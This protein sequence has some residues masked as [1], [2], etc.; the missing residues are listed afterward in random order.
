M[1]VPCERFSSVGAGDTPLLFPSITIDESPHW[2]IGLAISAFAALVLLLPVANA[3]YLPPAVTAALD[4]AGVSP[5]ALALTVLPVMAGPALLERN[6]A[7]PFQPASTMKLVTTVAA[8]DLLGANYRG[9]TELLASGRISNA[10]LHGN[11]YLRGLADADLDMP[12]LWSLLYKLHGL[13]VRKIHGNIIL[14]RS[15]FSPA[16][17][18]LGLPPF[19]ESPEWQYNVIPDALYLNGGLLRYA[20]ESND[21]AVRVRMEPPMFGVTVRSRMKLSALECK[22]WEKG[23]LPAKVDLMPHTHRVRISLQGEF[24]INCKA[25]A[26]LQL[27][28][29]DLLANRLIRQLWADMGGSLRGRVVNG[30]VSDKVRLLANHESRPLAEVLRHMNK[31]SDNPLTRLLFLSLGA[32]APGE[33]RERFATTREASA[34]RVTEW[35]ANH[36]ISTDG[37]VLDNGSGLSRSERITATQ[38]ASMLRFAWQQNYAPELLASMPLVGIDGTMRNRLKQS[39]ATGRARIKTGTLRN[40]TAVAGYVPDADQ[41]M[42]AISAMINHEKAAAAR[43]A[44]DALIDWIAGKSTAELMAESK[45]FNKLDDEIETR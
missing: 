39:A 43:P 37:L 42:W 5:E 24:P 22:K 40:T 28:D 21:Q 20:L 27:F 45:T 1:T 2:R 17:I 15:F 10:V 16:R 31:S 23:W 19:D 18:D 13:G 33:L 8:L 30:V 26:E 35:L 32:K 14:D 29:R 4:A 34:A 7:V 6:E 41:T 38:M 3:Q 36:D 9:K 25:D 44:L 12:T 11:I